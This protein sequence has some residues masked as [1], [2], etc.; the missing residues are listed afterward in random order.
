MSSTP[1]TEAEKLVTEAKESA[2]P[3]A[4]YLSQ[5]IERTLETDSNGTEGY[6]HHY[7]EPGDYEWGLPACDQ[8]AAE[9]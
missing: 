9:G 2:Q 5:R 3:M 6:R 8:T 7:L 4:A 1:L